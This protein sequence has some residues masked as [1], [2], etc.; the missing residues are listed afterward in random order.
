MLGLSRNDKKEGQTKVG[1]Q[2]LWGLQ[3]YTQ[4]IPCIAKPCDGEICYV[5]NKKEVCNNNHCQ[6]GCH[7]SSFSPG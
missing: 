7:S 3:A 2:T 6:C 5:I 4:Q 1:P